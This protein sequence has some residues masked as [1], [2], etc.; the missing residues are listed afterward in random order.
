VPFLGAFLTNCRIGDTDARGTCS[1][2]VSDEGYERLR[3]VLAEPGGPRSGSPLFFDLTSS[4]L[5][6]AEEIG[7]PVIA[8][9]YRIHPVLALSFGASGDGLVFLR[10]GDES[11]LRNDTAWTVDKSTQ[12]QPD[13]GNAPD[14][15]L[16]LLVAMRPARG[17]NWTTGEY[18]CALPPTLTKRRWPLRAATALVLDGSKGSTIVLATRNS[19]GTLDFMAIAFD[20]P[21]PRDTTGSGCVLDT[22]A[23]W[24][25]DSLGAR[26][27]PKTAARP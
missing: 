20:G 1:N 18:V 14:R 25:I 5:R 3:L 15:R 9:S 6:A 11:N 8:G 22:A 23:D 12:F 13:V 26:K 7:S 27:D 10:P 16:R 4:R 17:T 21:S 24:S 19:T 2:P